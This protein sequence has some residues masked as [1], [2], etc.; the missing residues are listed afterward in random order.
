MWSVAAFAMGVALLTL[1]LVILALHGIFMVVP[2]E[3]GQIVWIVISAFMPTF[4]IQAG[5]VIIEEGDPEV[6]GSKKR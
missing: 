4:F 1:V 5:R 3:M 6:N 2:L